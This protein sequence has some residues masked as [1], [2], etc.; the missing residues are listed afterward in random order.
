MTSKEE[1]RE[2]FSKLYEGIILAK[3]NYYKNISIVSIQNMHLYQFGRFIVKECV[4]FL[5]FISLIC[6]MSHFF[7]YQ[8][9]MGLMLLR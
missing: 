1:I 7:Y 6:L 3:H 2:I 4:L 9:K 8:K 5:S